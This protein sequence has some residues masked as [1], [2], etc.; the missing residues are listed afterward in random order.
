MLICPVCSLPLCLDGKTARCEKGHSFDVSKEGYLNLLMDSS[1]RGHG[2][3]KNML[4]ARRAFL[5]KGYYE[6][7]RSKLEETAMKLFPTNG[8]FL[9]AG[10]GEGYYTEGVLRRLY[11]SG[12][13]PHGFAFDI[14]KDAVRLCAKRL[15]DKGNFFVASTFHIPVAEESADLLFSLFAPYSENEFL[16]ILK[17]G[18]YLVR[19]VPLEDHLF[20]LKEKVYEN[21]TKNLSAAV[22]GEGFHLSEEVRVKKE[23]H[24]SSGEDIFN[25]FGMTPYAHKTS[26]RDIK[27]LSQLQSLD[28]EMDIGILIYCKRQ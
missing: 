16:R 10:C 26:P 12:K 5:E 23:I 9:D 2:D 11:E 6:P 24:L 14:S 25:L 7:L 1:A 28:T 17:P 4:L 22:I 8:T 13:N 19:A 15:R 27:K 3:D 20:S 21:P 18:G